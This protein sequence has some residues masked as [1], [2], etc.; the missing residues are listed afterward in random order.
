MPRWR[1]PANFDRTSPFTDAP[2]NPRRHVG[3][4]AIIA[5]IRCAIRNNNMTKRRH[6]PPSEWH[7]PCCPL[8]LTF[9]E[10]AKH[11]HD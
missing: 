3:R 8:S 5:V 2:E 10:E 11:E 1:C 9:P 4:L 6:Y 7:K